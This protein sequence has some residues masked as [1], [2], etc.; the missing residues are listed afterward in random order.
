MSQIPKLTS[1][2]ENYYMFRGLKI[3]AVGQK[4]P[5]T[6]HL[7][8]SHTRNARNPLCIFINNWNFETNIVWFIGFYQIISKKDGKV[9]LLLFLLQKQGKSLLLLLFKKLSHFHFNRPKLFIFLKKSPLVFIFRR[10]NLPK[11]LI[12]T[13]VIISSVHDLA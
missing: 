10:N 8:K 11:L 6:D 4:K 1:N 2:V 13:I 9:E 7:L 5:V 3:R 12:L